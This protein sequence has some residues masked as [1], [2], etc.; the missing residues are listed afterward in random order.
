MTRRQDQYQGDELQL[1]T[2]EKKGLKA[3][4]QQ[5]SGQVAMTVEEEY[6][7]L[8]HQVLTGNQNQVGYVDL[9]A[10]QKQGDGGPLLARK[11]V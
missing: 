2:G 9:L 6:R 10:Q 7:G 8:V 1:V 3:A 4:L 11:A 5:S